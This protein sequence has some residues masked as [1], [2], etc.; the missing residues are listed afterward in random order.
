MIALR[1]LLPHEQVLVSILR[2]GGGGEVGLE[3]VRLLNDPGLR[4]AF[5]R[6]A[7]QHGVLGLALSVL[8]R[9]P[10]F[11]SALSSSAAAELFAPLP[12]LRRQAAFWDLE[13]GRV[14]HRLQS[15]GVEPIVLK[16]G[17]LRMTTYADSIERPVA[18]LDLL[19]RKEEVPA[20]MAALEVAKYALA[21][22]HAR[23][24]YE[25]H[26]FHYVLQHPA[27]YTVEVH[28]GLT[29]PAAQVQ[30]DME[31]LRNRSIR[32]STPHLAWV[33]SREDMVLHLICQNVQDGFAKLQRTVDV[34]RVVSER[35]GF[36]WYYLVN[37]AGGGRVQAAAALT[38]QLG[39]RLLGTRLPQANAADMFSVPR[40][41]RAGLAS[42][43]PVTVHL[44][45]RENPRREL[46]LLWTTPGSKRWFWALGRRLFADHYRF[47]GIA[48]N[49]PPPS[50]VARTVRVA[51]LLAAQLWCWVAA[52]GGLMTRHG[53]A[54]LRFWTP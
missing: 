8:D 16:G 51:T 29:A 25:A 36:D 43:H 21:Y 38:L 17:A 54:A 19:V 7:H 45:R 53:R 1:R 28:W 12:T 3:K 18:D 35:D 23:G 34:D 2:R 15:N 37:A 13:R 9:T 39:H 31:A 49:R 14:V 48:A 26:H 20:A 40:V 52:V 22:G 4:T 24:L 42:I 41:A 11:V 33:P 47:W 6:D 27:G 50:I 46:L 10:E 30:L 44:R 5:Q 32:L